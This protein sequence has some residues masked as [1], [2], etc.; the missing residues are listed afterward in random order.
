MRG[1][2]VFDKRKYTPVMYV[3]KGAITTQQATLRGDLVKAGWFPCSNDNGLQCVHGR[4]R[5]IRPLV[6][7]NVSPSNDNDKVTPLRD[8]S[9]SLTPLTGILV[10]SLLIQFAH[11]VLGL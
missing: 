11:F 6:L 1:Q 5:K 2:G 10:L 8:K 3:S 4:I 9:P 7:G